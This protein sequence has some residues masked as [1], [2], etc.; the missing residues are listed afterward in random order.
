MQGVG[1]VRAGRGGK[2]HAWVGGEEKWNPRRKR[3]DRSRL[4]VGGYARQC[5][6]DTSW[7][8]CCDTHTAC[9]TSKSPTRA[10]IKT[11]RRRQSSTWPYNYAATLGVCLLA[12]LNDQLELRHSSYGRC[13]VGQGIPG[14]T[15]PIARSA[16]SKDTADHATAPCTRNDLPVRTAPLHAAR[17]RA[18]KN[19][20]RSGRCKSASVPIK[21]IPHVGPH[22]PLLRL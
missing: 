21:L 5:S 6:L 4:I 13:Q 9:V 22:R 10:I 15:T 20:T 2:E 3:V 7:R 12:I 14:S 18:W 1:G 16:V 11:R 8:L 19:T 17:A